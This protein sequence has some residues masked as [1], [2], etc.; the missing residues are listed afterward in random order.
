[1]ALRPLLRSESIH[2]CQE[3]HATASHPPAIAG[4]AGNRNSSASKMAY[5]LR[6][7]TKRSLSI[8]VI[9][10]AFCSVDSESKLL[11]GGLWR[12]LRYTIRV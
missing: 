12:N 3:I 1:V 2:G 11:C 10:N 6:L 7:R 4:S 8:D 9:L 5:C